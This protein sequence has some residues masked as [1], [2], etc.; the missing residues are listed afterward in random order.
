MRENTAINA[1][2]LDQSN[3]LTEQRKASRW[4][5]LFCGLHFLAWTLMPFLSR[6]NAPFDS[7]E[8]VA[9][10]NLWQWGY[11]KHPPLAPWLTA[12]MTHLF[13]N[14]DLGI[15]LLSQLS[16]IICFWAMWRLANKILTPWR[17]LIGVVLL[18]GI[19]YYNVASPQFNPNIL[20]LATWAL[21]SLTFYNALKGQRWHHWLLCGV[22]AG[23]AMMTKYEA[24]LLFVPMLFVLCGTDIGRKSLRNF[25]FYG[26]IIAGI[27][28]FSPHLIWLAEHHFDAVIYAAGRMDNPAVPHISHWLEHFYQPL[29]FVFEQTAALLPILLLFIPFYIRSNERLTIASFDRRFLLLMGLGPFVITFLIS[30]VTAAWIHSLWAFPFFSFIGIL[31]VTFWQPKVDEKRLRNFTIIVVVFSLIVILSR[32]LFLMYGPLWKGKVTAANFPG[33]NIALNLTEQWHALYHQ[34]M[35][36][37]AGDHTVV[38]NVAAYSKD[39]PIANFNWSQADSPWLNEKDMRTKGA[40]FVWRVQNANDWQVVKMISKRYPQ[41]THVQVESF[42]YLTKANITPVKIWVAFLPPKNFYAQ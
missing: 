38:I 24:A 33:K 21:T 8:G 30:M 3:A 31:L 6:G 16:V 17:A 28:V 39:Q 35:P 10:G 19:Y 20:M 12:S 34:P 40:V 18:E 15:Y 13:G 29:R 22:C 36:Y 26:G 32:S 5:Y 27:L 23:L 9:W 25:A 14:V 41:I 11:E 7:V 42:N 4:F 1:A 2:S 37:I